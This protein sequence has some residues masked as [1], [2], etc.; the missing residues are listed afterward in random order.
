MHVVPTSDCTNRV[1]RRV[2]FLCALHKAQIKSLVSQYLPDTLHVKLNGPPSSSRVVGNGL[3]A[4]TMHQGY[5]GFLLERWQTGN[6][7]M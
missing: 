1:N 4:V 6:G 7:F 2:H 3:N 5:A